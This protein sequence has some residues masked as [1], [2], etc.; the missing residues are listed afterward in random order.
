M[1]WVQDNAT[2]AFQAGRRACRRTLPQECGSGYCKSLLKAEIKMPRQPNE[3]ALAVFGFPCSRYSPTFTFIFLRPPSIRLHSYYA[4]LVVCVLLTMC[5]CVRGFGNWSAV[6]LA[7]SF[8]GITILTILLLLQ[9]ELQ[10]VKWSFEFPLRPSVSTWLM[11]SIFATPPMVVVVVM[12]VQ[13][14]PQP[15]QLHQ[16]HPLQRNP[17][18]QRQH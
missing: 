17:E 7:S 1:W 16:L 14:H 6:R 5:S 9:A 2:L 8:C 12:M 10:N 11:P 4:A 18:H 13:H 15:Q 3:H